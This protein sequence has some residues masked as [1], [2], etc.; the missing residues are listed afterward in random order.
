MIYQLSKTTFGRLSISTITV[1]HF[2]F[3]FAWNILCIWVKWRVIHMRNS[4]CVIMRSLVMY[5]KYFFTLWL[6]ILLMQYSFGRPQLNSLSF[7]R[8]NFTPSPTMELLI[9][10]LFNF[11]LKDIRENLFWSD[12]LLFLYADWQV[13]V[14]DKVC[15]G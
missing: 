12:S 10:K 14:R 8:I 3:P 1:S 5:V 4:Y 13:F 9:D 11:N 6:T 2:A 15:L 7:G